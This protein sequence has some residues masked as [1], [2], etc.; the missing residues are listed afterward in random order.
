[1]IKDRIYK[2]IVIGMLLIFGLV[3]FFSVRFLRAQISAATHPLSQIQQD[4]SGALDLDSW[5]KIKHRF[6]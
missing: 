4:S 2:L 5:E 3:F 1:M 6:E